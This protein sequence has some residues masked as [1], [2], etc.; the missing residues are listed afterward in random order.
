MA[1][2]LNLI[3]R[4]AAN[5]K[6]KP[7]QKR[8]LSDKKRGGG[9]KPLDR[10]ES[11]KADAKTGMTV[12]VSCKWQMDGQVLR[13]AAVSRRQSATFCWPGAEPVASLCISRM[14]PGQSHTQLLYQVMSNALGPWDQLTRELSVS[15][16]L[17]HVRPGKQGNTG[18]VAFTKLFSPLDAHKHTHTRA[19]TCARCSLM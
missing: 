9:G 16:R 7:R 5:P 3:E 18:W 12:I 14:P 11:S 19:H 8:P 10:C 1:F 13:L 6:E 4:R 17:L 15:L 2:P